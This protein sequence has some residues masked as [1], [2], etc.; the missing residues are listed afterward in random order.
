MWFRVWNELPRRNGNQLIKTIIWSPYMVIKILWLIV[1]DPS[2][3]QHLIELTN[4]LSI[5]IASTSTSLTNRKSKWFTGSPLLLHQDVLWVG[6]RPW[7]ELI[8]WRR[9]SKLQ[10]GCSHAIDMKHMV[11]WSVTAH[12]LHLAVNWISKQKPSNLIR[13]DW[14]DYIGSVS[15]YC[16]KNH[17]SRWCMTAEHWEE[18]K[19]G[20]SEGSP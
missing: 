1:F 9:S 6:R 17:D 11:V 5:Q 13:N 19:Y 2:L 4:E 8:S 14:I 7:S 10:K 15:S 3:T 16:L 20:L 12:F 18:H